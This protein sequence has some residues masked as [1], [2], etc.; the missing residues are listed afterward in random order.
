MKVISLLSDKDDDVVTMRVACSS[1]TT[2]IT[3]SSCN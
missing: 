3:D 1:A 2:G